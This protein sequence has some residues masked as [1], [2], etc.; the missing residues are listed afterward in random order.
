VGIGGGCGGHVLSHTA[1]RHGCAEQSLFAQ[2]EPSGP[3]IDAEE[4]AKDAGE[5]PATQTEC[6]KQSQ[7]AG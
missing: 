3:R 7:L 5:T 2:P 1:G 4:D 6:A